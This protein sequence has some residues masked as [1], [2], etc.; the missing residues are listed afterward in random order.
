MDFKSVFFSIVLSIV[1]FY[2]NRRFIVKTSSKSV[3]GKYLHTTESVPSWSFLSLEQL[4]NLKWV[5][6]V[7]TFFVCSFVFYE[8]EDIALVLIFL[9]FIFGLFDNKSRKN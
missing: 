5:F 9:T 3:E 2:V 6:I 4:K 1:F 8:N 7:V